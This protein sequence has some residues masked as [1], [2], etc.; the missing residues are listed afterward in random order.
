MILITVLLF[1]GCGTTTQNT[2]GNT[3]ETFVSSV[4]E[5]TT[6]RTFTDSVGREV[7]IPEAITK[8]APSG[9]LAQLVLYTA[10]PDSLIGLSAEFSGSAKELIPEKYQELPI[11]GQ[12]YGKNANLNLE[13]LSAAQPDVVIDIGEAKKTVVEDMDALQKQINIPTIFI[14]AKL[15][16]MEET[17][18]MLGELLG[19]T[20]RTKEL[21]S[22]CQKVINQANKIN[23]DL[24]DKEKASIYYA[25]GDAGLDTNAKGSIHAEIFEVVGA[26]NVV[27]GVEAASKGGGTTISMEQLIQ[28]QPEYILAETESVYHQILA[29]ETWKEL[30]A[31]KEKNVYLIPSAPYNFIGAPPSVNR[32][33]GI[34]WLGNLLYPESYQ[35]DI[36]ATVKEFYS[37]FYSIDL[38]KPQLESVLKNS[39]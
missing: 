32:I 17:Y 21:S 2:D 39:Q 20:D 18:K 23:K 1:S 5:A 30:T 10:A 27:A 24:T 29:E 35:L 13:A 36:E 16:N 34:Q 8:I 11:F 31:V 7:E 3:E 6:T 37:L 22:Y 4:N 33:L 12:F 28:W 38:T 9:P 26:E 25:S 14:E 15:E 19:N